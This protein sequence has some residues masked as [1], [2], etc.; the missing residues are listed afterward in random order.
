MEMTEN[1]EW[2][3]LYVGIL[4]DDKIQS[5]S[6]ADQRRFLML[7]CLRG[8]GAI[9]PTDY[10]VADALG[11]DSG[12]WERTKGKLIDRGLIDSQNRVVNWD[13]RQRDD[14]Y[15]WPLTEA[16]PAPAPAAPEPGKRGLKKARPPEGIDKDIF[17]LFDETMPSQIPRPRKLSKMTQTQIFARIREDP[18]RACLDWWKEYFD[19][20]TESPFL[21]G[22]S[23][24]DFRV[25]LLW[26]LGPRNMEKILS[27]MYSRGRGLQGNS[28]KTAIAIRDWVN[29]GRE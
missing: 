24:T 5:L 29:D 1:I 8:K 19:T 17:D 14:L 20:I 28:L 4:D 21:M 13:R 15:S 3:K 7:L 12:D 26:V 6:E 11:I 27:G 22:A 23:D 18:E 2:C 10:D 25:S 9:Q 16:P